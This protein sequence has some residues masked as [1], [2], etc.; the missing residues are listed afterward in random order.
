MKKRE[1]RVKSLAF[2]LNKV[3]GGK[4]A[5]FKVDGRKELVLKDGSKVYCSTPKLEVGSQL[6]TDKSS[7]NNPAPALPLSAG[8][9]ELNTGE[10]IKVLEGGIVGEIVKSKSKFTEIVIKKFTPASKLK[11]NGIQKRKV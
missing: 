6:I 2:T 7:V 8:E 5:T 9:Y 1:A 4:P 3:R 10:K 11:A